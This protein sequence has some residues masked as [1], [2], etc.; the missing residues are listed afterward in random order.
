[1]AAL[2]FGIFLCMQAPLQILGVEGKAMVE[3]ANKVTPDYVSQETLFFW[4]TGSLSLFLDNAPTYVVFFEA[5]RVMVPTSEAELAD[6]RIRIRDEGDHVALMPMWKMDAG[7]TP[8]RLRLGDEE[9]YIIRKPKCDIIN[10]ALAA[11]ERIRI[12]GENEDE[13]FYVTLIPKWKKVDRHGKEVFPTELTDTGE[14]SMRWQEIE[15]Q[16]RSTI[17]RGKLVPIR[18][19]FIDHY[20]LIAIALGTVFM[21]GMTY[22]ANAPN[23]LVKSIAEHDGV[24]MPSFFGFMAYSCL[25]LLPVITIMMLIF[26]A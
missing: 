8:E 17:D 20:L 6:E 21:G 24:P 16:W 22:I 14:L 5:G 1:V 2:F 7:H 23:F 15:G 4:T 13:P 10:A 9:E 19:G 12:E 3:R 11:A 18:N 25:L 26:I